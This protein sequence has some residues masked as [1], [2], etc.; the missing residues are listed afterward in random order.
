MPPLLESTA[1]VVPLTN[2]LISKGYVMARV[3][4]VA[5]SFVGSAAWHL[6]KM[7]LVLQPLPR[8]VVTTLL[9]RMRFLLAADLK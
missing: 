2:Q 5:I 4:W 9:I 1:T 8:L 7:A 3:F 6:P